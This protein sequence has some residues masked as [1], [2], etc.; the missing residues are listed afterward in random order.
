M[1]R[2]AAPFHFRAAVAIAALSFLV[3]SCG[4]DAV[5]GPDNSIARIS[6]NPPSATMH[7]GE[8]LQLTAKAFNGG[9][10]PIAGR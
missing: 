3:N 2:S 6:L 10:T 4:G 9:N 8:T 1:R 5:A 7:L